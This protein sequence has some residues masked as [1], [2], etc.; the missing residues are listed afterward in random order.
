MEEPLDLSVRKFQIAFESNTQCSKVKAN[1]NVLFC[2]FCRKSFDRPSLLK[3]HVRTHTGNFKCNIKIAERCRI[4]TILQ[5]RNH[6]FAIS[7]RRDFQLQVLL[8][9][10]DE[11]ILD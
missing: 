7:V 10:I 8:I 5:V 3:R 9:H 2:E 4:D 6:M 1:K 11:Y